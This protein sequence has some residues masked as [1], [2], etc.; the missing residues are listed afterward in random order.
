MGESYFSYLANLPDL[1]VLMDEAHRYYASA[2]AQAL[3]DLNPVLGIEL[4]ATPKRWAQ[5]PVISET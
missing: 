2:G 1:V 4:T 5:I 3:N